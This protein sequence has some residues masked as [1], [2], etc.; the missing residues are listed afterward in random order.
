MVKNPLANAGDRHGFDPWFG[1]KL[2]RDR[3]VP[4]GRHNVVRPDV[5]DDRRDRVRPLAVAGDRHVKIL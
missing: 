5:E 1:I 2:R 4:I 3:D